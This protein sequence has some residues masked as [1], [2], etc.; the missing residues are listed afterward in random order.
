[1]I[2]VVIT[3]VKNLWENM[4]KFLKDWTFKMMTLFMSQIE[5]LHMNSKNG[6]VTKITILPLHY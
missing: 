1:M 4:D 2:H 3:L 5:N 6:F